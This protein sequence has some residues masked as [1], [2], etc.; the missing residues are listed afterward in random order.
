VEVAVWVP[1][2][3]DSQGTSR[4]RIKMRPPRARRFG[5]WE[6]AAPAAL[7][8]S[9][10]S[11]EQL[12]AARPSRAEDRSR[13]AA[14]HAAAAEGSGVAMSARG[15]RPTCVVRWRLGRGAAGCGDVGLRCAQRHATSAWLQACET[16][17][18]VA[19]ASL[20]KRWPGWSV[21]SA[22]LLAVGAVVIG[23]DGQESHEI[24]FAVC[25]TAS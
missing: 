7:L 2:Y 5:F 17:A 25:R 19:R 8:F 14:S 11:K 23:G 18:R 24:A 12:P 1:V 16:P 15:C 9:N 4:R 13:R 20:R 21:G 6:G 22:L 10:E 3:G